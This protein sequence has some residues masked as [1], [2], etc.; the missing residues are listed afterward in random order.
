VNIGDRSIIKEANLADRSIIKESR[1]IVSALSKASM[2]FEDNFS[3]K[4]PSGRKGK[5]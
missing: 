3:A 2:E 1:P 5:A 4:P